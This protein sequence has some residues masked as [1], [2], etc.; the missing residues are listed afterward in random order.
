MNSRCGIG[1][2]L[3]L[4]L[5]LL[6]CLHVGGLALSSVVARGGEFAI[7]AALGA[8]RVRL[9]RQLVLETLVVAGAGTILGIGVAWLAVKPIASALPFG[10][11]QPTLDITKDERLLFVTALAGLV[12]GLVASLLPASTLT[13]RFGLTRSIPQPRAATSRTRLRPVSE[14][15]A[16]S[17]MPPRRLWTRKGYRE[18][19]ELTAARR[20]PVRHT[21]DSCATR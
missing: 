17:I 1:S 12:T 14:F 4:G 19:S 20:S 3:T 9:A 2:A 16:S 18:R 15:D 13:R 7:R 6:A 10:G 11:L 5:L 8:S 21:L